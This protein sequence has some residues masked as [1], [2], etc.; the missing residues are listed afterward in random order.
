MAARPVTE[1]RVEFA[2]ALAVMAIRF[3]IRFSMLGWRRLDGT[4]F[5]CLV[6]TV[7]AASLRRNLPS[8]AFFLTLAVFR[9]SISALRL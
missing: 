8:S 1:S 7:W 9:S 3:G 4:D 6:S 2:I 5:W